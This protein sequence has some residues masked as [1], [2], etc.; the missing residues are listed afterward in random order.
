[1]PQSKKA[2]FNPFL[3]E[4]FDPELEQLEQELEQLDQEME[5]EEPERTTIRLF[6][7]EGVEKVPQSNKPDSNPIRKIEPFDPNWK[8][9]NRN[10][11]S[12]TSCEV[13]GVEEWR[14]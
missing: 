7:I 9:R 10:W 4:P 8:S 6:R 5:E 11:S 1:M 3:I 2:G 14:S 12:W 13:A